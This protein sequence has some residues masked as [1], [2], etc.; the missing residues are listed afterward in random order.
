MPT[1]KHS[2]RWIDDGVRYIIVSFCRCGRD[3]WG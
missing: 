3:N 2:G 1:H